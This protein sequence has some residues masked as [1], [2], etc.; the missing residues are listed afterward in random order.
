MKTK[1]FILII[2]TTLAFFYM[3][4]YVFMIPIFRNSSV[5]GWIRWCVCGLWIATFFYAN[6]R[7]KNE[8]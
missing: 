3:V 8:S 6:V 2:I 1:D 5:L 7:D 4:G